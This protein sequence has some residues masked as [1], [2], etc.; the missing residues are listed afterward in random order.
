MPDAVLYLIVEEAAR[1]VN[2]PEFAR[3]VHM[4]GFCASLARTIAEL[5]AAGCDSARLAACLPDAPLSAVAA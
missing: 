5:S 2:R 4:Q 1:R 3:V